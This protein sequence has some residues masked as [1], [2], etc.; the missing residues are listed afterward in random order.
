VRLRQ[1]V[2]RIDRVEKQD[3]EVFWATPLDGRETRSQRFHRYLERV[4]PGQLPRPSAAAIGDGREQARLLTAQRFALVHGTAPILGV[5]RSRAIPTDYQLVPLLLSLG[6]DRVRLLIADTVGTGKTVEAGLVLTEL[7]ARGFARRVLVAVPANL[8]DQWRDALEH[9]FHIDATVVAGQ[10]M[11]A[12]ERQLMPGQSVWSAHDVVVASI[13]YL[14]ARASTVLMHQWD[15]IV[16]DEAHL[17]AKP[18]TVPGS[19]PPDMARW[20]FVAEAARCCEHLL[21]LTATPHN[22][23]SDSFTSLFEMLDPKLVG[24]SPAGPWVRRQQA[25]RHVVQR[26]RRDIERWYKQQAIPY[27]F[28][29]RDADEL[30]VPLTGATKL[31]VLLEELSGYTAALFAAD[32]TRPINGWVA[33]HFQKR[34]LSSP[35]ALRVSL[36]NR[37]RALRARTATPADRKATDEAR[38]SVADLLFDMRDETDERTDRLDV[39]E[40]SLDTAQE[41]SFLT[42]LLALA[43]GI[44]AKQD[45]KLQVLLRLV[46]ERIAAHPDAPRVMVFTKYR[47]TLDYLVKQLTQAA[48]TVLDPGLPPKHSI[49]AIYGGLTL[50]DRRRVFAEFERASPAVLIAT[51]CI[52]EGLN[53]Q[54]ACADLVHY[55]LPWNPNRLEQR[56]G[57]IDRFRQR[58]PVVGIRTL[59]LDN[60]L[61]AALLELIVRKSKQ[62]QEDYGFV[63]PFLSNPDLLVRL[64]GVLSQRHRTAPTLFEAAGVPDVAIAEDDLLD[65]GKLTRIHSESFYGQDQVSL[66][67]VSRALR[68]SSEEVGNPAALEAFCA[69]SITTL[70]GVEFRAVRPRV[71]RL[72]GRNREIADVWPDSDRLLAFD[73]IIGFNDPTVDVV[74]LAHPLLRRLVDLGLERL[75]NPGCRGRI[76]ARLSTATHMVCAVLWLLIRYAAR[77]DPPVLL[78]ELMPMSCPVYGDGPQPPPATTVL[79]GPPRDA[80]KDAEDIADAAEVLFA[81]ADLDDRINDHTRRRA[82]QLSSGYDELDAAWAEGLSQVEVM[83]CDVVAATIVWPEILR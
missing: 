24:N 76:A 70:E 3:Q 15:V 59:V 19:A 4:E 65:H 37:L 48:E 73:P 71:Y 50:A 5:Q 69:E 58:E 81:R 54:H 43:R 74:D 47:D 75:R 40:M 38:A 53:L 64:S 52:S 6:A 62:M 63:P 29:R 1:R 30:V 57:R 49:F 78:E 39:A 60:P 10:L 20:R 56:N 67:T 42:R 26:T 66:S 28:P 21:L 79:A 41:T 2:W 34:A 35:E 80:P 77:T 18:H 82:A 45:P 33:A 83:S 31:R 16:V 27:P 11:P 17:C 44:T 72:R 7:L 36:C 13:D 68:R 51:D 25:A 9:F 46:P 8:R 55:E 23:Y 14:K 22:G 12:L 61:D 32:T